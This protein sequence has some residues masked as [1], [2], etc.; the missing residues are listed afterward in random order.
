MGEDE[1]DGLDPKRLSRI[2]GQADRLVA[3]GRLT[4]D[5]AQRLRAAPDV[6]RAEQVVRE[7]RA[8][9]ASER[10]DAAVAEGAMSR[11]E[12]DDLLARVRGGEH[13]RALRSH[14]SRFRVKPRKQPKPAEP[15]SQSEDS[16]KRPA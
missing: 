4:A 6:S 11:H 10:L 16:G 15:G 13:S 1:I 14:L 5:E 2:A 9:H 12:A 8:R 7:I 3:A